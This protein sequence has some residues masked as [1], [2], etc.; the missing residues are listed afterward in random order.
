M[1]KVII[2]YIHFYTHRNARHI[3]YGFLGSNLLTITDSIK[4]LI[5]LVAKLFMVYEIV[6]CQDGLVE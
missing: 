5:A 4:F 2:D 3:S 6:D 1:F